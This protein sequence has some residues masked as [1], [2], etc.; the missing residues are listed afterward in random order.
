MMHSD[1][2]IVPE[3]ELTQNN[4]KSSFA[5]TFVGNGMVGLSHGT[6]R[7]TPHGTYLGSI[8]T[9]TRQ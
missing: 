4:E 9:V 8:L 3:L 1:R 5:G 2:E 7:F 6:Q